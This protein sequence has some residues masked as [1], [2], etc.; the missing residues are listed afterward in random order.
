[1]D[2][3]LIQAAIAT[4]DTQRNMELAPARYMEMGADRMLAA[5]GMAVSVVR[6]E[7][8]EATSDDLEAVVE[9]NARLAGEVRN[10][11]TAGSY[12]LVLGGAC[13][14][15]LGAI[16]GLGSH[17]G[18]VWL[19][20]HGDFNTPQTS[21]SGYFDGMPLAITTGRCHTQLRDRVGGTPLQEGL[22]LLAGVRDLDPERRRA[23]TTR[24]SSWSRQ[25]RGGGSAWTRRCGPLWICLP[26]ALVRSTCTLTSTCW[27]LCT[28]QGLTSPHRKGFPWV[29]WR[30]ALD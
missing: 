30:R 18:V 1:M 9:V 10:A 14:V 8:G 29:M 23:W 22:V 25:I 16:A 13:N 12:P 3:T 4:G 28:P 24:R 11:L 21:P 15:C 20:A 2:V 6:V 5:G 7:R 26:V 27:I 19:D 17:V